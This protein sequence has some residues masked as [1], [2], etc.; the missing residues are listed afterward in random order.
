[1]RKP[2]S[3]PAATTTVHLTRYSILALTALALSAQQPSDDQEVIFRVETEL[4]E[5]EVRVVG[6]G[7]KPVTDLKKEDFT[8]KENGRQQTIATFEFIGDPQNLTSP[9]QASSQSNQPT[10]A[11]PLRASPPNRV[12]IVTEA[13]P[14]DQR[15]I[16]DAIRTYL[17]EQWRP[18]TLVS[19]GA[20]PFTADPRQLRATLESMFAAPFGERDKQTGRW[21]EGLIDRPSIEIARLE[22]ERLLTVRQAVEEGL[23][24]AQDKANRVANHLNIQM[25]P[26]RLRNIDQQLETLNRR[27]LLNYQGL[28]R[29]LAAYPGKKV[30]VLFR[31][32]LRVDQ[33]NTNLSQLLAAEALRSRVSFYTVNSR[34]LET[35]SVTASAGIDAKRL[36]GADPNRQDLMTEHR[37]RRQTDQLGLRSLAELTGGQAVLNSNRLADVFD[38]VSEDS[39]SYY[40]L[41]YYPV[42]ERKSGR[43]RRISVAVNRSGVK[44]YTGRG[45]YEPKPFAEMSKTEK[46]L[47]LEHVLHGA[48]ASRDYS[49]RVGHDFFRGDSERTLM[50]FGVSVPMANLLA[51]SKKRGDLIRF[52]VGIHAVDLDRGSSWTFRSPIYEYAFGRKGLLKQ[53]L[54][55]ETF[56]DYTEQIPLPPGRYD[57]KVVLLDEQGGRF[58]AAQQEVTVPDF[59]QP[60]SLSSLLL[61]SPAPAAGP[62][63]A[64]GGKS[65]RRPP[66]ADRVLTFKDSRFVPEYRGEF[67]QGRPIFLLYDL[68]KV[69]SEEMATPPP[70]R[71]ILK[72]DGHEIE[73]F[74]AIGDVLPDPELRRIRYLAGLETANL[75]PGSYRISAYVPADQ[76]KTVKS[77]SEHFTLLPR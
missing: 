72:R 36:L 17:D 49:L 41:G 38:R 60:S 55:G 52:T 40:L 24:D 23:S 70:I 13:T 14:G 76:G 48:T 18:G 68:Y 75:P 46:I 51:Q 26:P 59:S 50:L 45:Y 28:I 25:R 71:L 44:A 20:R 16:Y 34:G 62:S 8:L 77:I 35:M 64:A 31:P 19:I 7:R 56:L 32:G 27:A 42:T 66:P 54:D 4:A 47:N 29:R 11:S 53:G 6:K 1:M 65:K 63:G 22:A 15:F 74:E 37:S 61:T 10:P 2:V 39:S 30:V 5:I 73:T 67:Q 57:W 43:F 69:S 3:I 12:Y 58:G 21:T 9:D 33:D